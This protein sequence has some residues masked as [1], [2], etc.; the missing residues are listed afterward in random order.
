[1]I[2]RNETKSF[3]IQNLEFGRN[4]KIYIQSMCNTKTKDIT[5][6]VNQILELEKLGCEIIR[7]AVLDE[8]D[9]LSIG[10]IK[11]QIHI[12]LVAD[13]HF[14]P[15]LAIISINQGVD[16]IRLNPGN[17]NNKDKII[18]IVNLCKEKNIPIRIGVNA[19]SLPKD[20]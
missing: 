10:K 15:E 12:P 7:V 3:K 20:I 16:K 8:Q 2:K 9:A 1:M 13:I 6:T 17:I 11:E 18:E 14:D 5:S 4:N 19:G